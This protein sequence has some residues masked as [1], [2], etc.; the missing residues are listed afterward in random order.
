[1]SGR[2]Y[3]KGLDELGYS[4]KSRADAAGNSRHQNE[5]E[6]GDTQT[7]WVSRIVLMLPCCL[8]RCCYVP[9]SHHDTLGALC[10]RQLILSATRG[11]L[12]ASD[13]ILIGSLFGDLINIRSVFSA[14]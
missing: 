14:F 7:C 1:M 4:R 13:S 5:R 8:E 9:K 2:G 11:L 6:G 10:D 12:E 3:L